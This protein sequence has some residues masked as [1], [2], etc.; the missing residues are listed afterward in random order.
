MSW[1]NAKTFTCNL[2]K[3][4]FPYDKFDEHM[5]KICEMA[6]FKPD[7]QLC[8]STEFESEDKII[9]HWRQE[10]PRMKVACS[11]C[12]LEFHRDNRH[13]CVEALLEARKG[14]KLLIKELQD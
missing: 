6:R 1:L 7:C 5:R 8:G 10:C 2:C 11:R 3:T 12:D 14:D 9:A 13:D 4:V